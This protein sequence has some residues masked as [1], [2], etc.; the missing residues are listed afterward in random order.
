MYQQK[1]ETLLAE[2]S[3]GLFER[4]QELRL[5]LL[6]MLS[7]KSI[8]LYGPPGVAKSQIARSVAKAFSGE[9]QFFAYLMNR[10][11]T[12]EEI[13]G[14]ID[15]AELKKNNL[16]R[17]VDGYLPT[18]DFAFL[19][20]IWKSSPAI[21]NTLLTIINERIYRDG[22]IDLQ[23]PLKGIVCASNEFPPDNQ[24][25]EAL[26][27]RM[28]IRYCVKPIESKQN[29][30]NL[31]TG[32][33]PESSITQTF[34]LKD[35]ED[36]AT[37]AKKIKFSNDALMAIHMLKQA[38]SD[39]KDFA[40]TY[41]IDLPQEEAIDQDKESSPSPTLDSKDLYISD[42]RWKQCA[43]LLQVAAVLSDRESVE[44][45]DV[46]LLKH[47]LWNTEI[48]KV[49]VDKVFETIFHTQANVKVANAQTQ[50]ETLEQK[51]ASE[52]YQKNGTMKKMQTQLE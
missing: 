34:S 20:E 40:N 19:D 39:Y 37:R 2:L 31:I 18:A 47:C 3:R 48:A 16:K 45:Y 6:S 8:F 43:E 44:K 7:G 23:V 25:L 22:N 21:L 14:P 10:F 15:I 12:P 42:R 33:I 29:F 46:A 51:I 52:L 28:V 41:N 26:Y 27:D 50:L 4:D 24:G 9:N 35:Y 36:I 38:L 13:F 32:A 5:V 30:T 1:V 17:K 49:F 11:S